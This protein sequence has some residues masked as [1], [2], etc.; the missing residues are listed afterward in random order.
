MPLVN[1]SKVV[2]VISVLFPTVDA[3]FPK[4]KI[5]RFQIVDSVLD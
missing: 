2:N 3:L 4:V 1:D 5:G